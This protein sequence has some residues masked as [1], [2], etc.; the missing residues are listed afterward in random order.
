M[1]RTFRSALLAFGLLFGV[2]AG[3][4]AAGQERQVDPRPD[5]FSCLIKIS[6]ETTKLPEQGGKPTPFAG[7]WL[8]ARGGDNDFSY[9]DEDLDTKDWKLLKTP[10]S[11]AGAYPGEP[12]FSVGWYRAVVQWESD[13]LGKDMV[14]LVS[15]RLSRVTVYIDGNEVYNRPGNFSVERF[16][17]NQPIPVIFKAK[18]TQQTIAIK[19]Q[20]LT[21]DGIYELPFEIRRYSTNDNSLTW[22][23]YRGGEF[24]LT[25]G[26]AIFFFGLFFLLVYVKIRQVMYLSAAMASFS[27][28]PYL[29]LPSDV[30]LRTF[31]PELM[32]ILQFLGLTCVFYFSV[33]CQAFDK[34][35]PK[36]NWFMGVIVM[37]TALFMASFAFFNW[38]TYSL[39]D[40]STPNGIDDWLAS[41][42]MLLFSHAR[43]VLFFAN[44]I[45]ILSSIFHTARGTL[46]K[47]EG[48]LVLLV[49]MTIYAVMFIHDALLALGYFQ[50][51]AMVPFDN[52]IFS[53]AMVWVASS[54]FA[55]TFKDNVRLV[56]DLKGINDN[57]EN[58]VA[59]R[60]AELHE[61]NVNIH[62]MLQNMRQGILMIVP[63]GAVHPEY[64]RYLEQ[65]LDSKDIAGK[66]AMELIFQGA[67]IGSDA[68]DSLVTSIGA[69]IGEDQMNF[70]FNSHLLINEF[71]KTM[72]DG[73]VKSLALAWSPICDDNSEIVE[74]LM[75]VIRDVSELKK[76]A[77]EAEHQ[78]RE[79]EMI[80][81]VLHI[82][83]EKFHEFIDSSR[84]FI[85]ENGKLIAAATD[86]DAE[87]VTQLFRNMH[88][89]KGNA[90][91]YGFLHLTNVVHEAEAAY[92]ELRK[93][94][95]A[96]FDKDAL[97]T[98]LKE[99]EVSV[100]EYATINDVKLGRKGPGRRGSAEKYVM[101]QREQVEDMVAE[102]AT[103]N[104]ADSD[105]AAIATTIKQLEHKLRLIGTE[106]IESVLSGVFD[107]LPSLAK[108]LD[109]EA[110][111]L[112][113]NDNGI[114]IRNQV[115]DLLRN[116]FMHLYR[117]SMDH[118]IETRAERLASGKPAAGTITLDLFMK[119]NRLAMRLRDDGK[120]LALGYIRKKGIEKGMVA[121]NDQVADE[122]VAQLIFAAGFSTA[123]AVTEVS[124]RGVGMDAVQDFIKREGGDITLEFTDDKKGAD[125]RAFE[126]VITLPGQFAVAPL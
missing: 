84:S 45:L 50:G 52:I 31:D 59:Q 25:A 40:R 38:T 96:V 54:T 71:N 92:D 81:Q 67:D 30:A 48:A 105:K 111:Q 116:V 47:R 20:S 101:V 109:K 99:V 118:G 119:D 77:A 21:Q 1:N 49:G 112:A 8:F 62:A 74:K 121:E 90:R 114:F 80:G 75:V 13:Q 11:W 91:T 58:I 98:Q 10:G 15:S 34:Y 86:K 100:E 9:G 2:I 14:L 24:R 64:S 39:V 27:A 43:T 5:C 3:V 55:S 95:E 82:N 126:T 69:C 125:F 110:P 37:G 113:V 36:F 72:P 18:T 17:A 124:G 19:V 88:T 6:P 117:N 85:E 16:F 42:N 12:P 29:L 76:L 83:Q 33:F 104:L 115:T 107:S 4:F 65:I 108:E 28:A 35:T 87:V 97:L 68:R 56:T 120:G 26:V 89:I 102:I 44:L 23:Q 53:M 123:A 122:D 41:F 78:K 103:I 94:A 51:I 93:D 7:T 57:L 61:K 66:D 63:G 106:S 22:H 79:L 46:Q 32:L 60:T 70:E 73:K